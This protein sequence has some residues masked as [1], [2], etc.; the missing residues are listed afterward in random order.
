MI[1]T[2][3]NYTLILS[4]VFTGLSTSTNADTNTATEVSS[5]D[6]KQLQDC[7]NSNADIKV[8][9]DDSTGEAI[10]FIGQAIC[11][12]KSTVYAME[13]QDLT[14][15]EI[16]ENF[17]DYAENYFNFKTLSKSVVG[18]KVVKEIRN[19]SSSRKELISLI[20]DYFVLNISTRFLEKFKQSGKIEYIYKKAVQRDKKLFIVTTEFVL[21]R[22][23]A[24]VV[25]KVKKTRKGLS[26][27][28]I[29]AGNISYFIVLQNEIR[30]YFKGSKGTIDL[31]VAMENLAIQNEKGKE[32]IVELLK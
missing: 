24:E 8:S 12:L 19:M 4:L 20:E 32:K 18:R 28:D 25:W 9:E 21:P 13:G 14:A 3:K 23:N 6:N 27:V 17:L 29:N 15:E 10:L 1:T 11:D 30:P 31:E 2:I 26:I 5:E 22:R 16:I 7:E